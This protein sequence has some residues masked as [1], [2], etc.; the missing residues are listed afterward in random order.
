MCR[1]PVQDDTYRKSDQ[2]SR[3]LFNESSLECERVVIL[4]FLLAESLRW[5]L[6]KRDFSSCFHIER[7]FI[8][9]NDTISHEWG[10]NLY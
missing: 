6:K 8:S 9:L 2:R 3:Q 5:F 1:F 10:L 7:P 4:C